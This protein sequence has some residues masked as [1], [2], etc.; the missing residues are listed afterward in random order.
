MNDREIWQTTNLNA[1][2]QRLDKVRS[3]R[4]GCFF[5]QQSGNQY[6]KVTK[7]KS[8][9]TLGFSD[10]FN[11]PANLIQSELDCDRP[12]NLKSLYT[13]AMM[14]SLVWN[15]TPQRIY[16]AGLGGG[17]IPLVLHHYFPE[18][19]IECAEIDPAILQVATNFFGLKLDERLSVAIQDGRE[20]LAQQNAN[21]KYDIILSDVFLGTGYSPYRLATQ[22][23]YELCLQR[24]SGQG[25]VVVNLFQDDAFFADK[26]LTIK[27]VF[28]Q[29][30]VVL[31]SKMGNAIVIA[32][33]GDIRQKRE[34]MAKAKNLANRYQFEFPLAE[35]ALEV[36]M[37]TQLQE[38]VPK[39]EKAR[40]LLDDFP[41][42]D[43][44][45]NLPAVNPAIART[46][47]SRFCMCGSGK[48]Q[49]DCHG[50]TN[51]KIIST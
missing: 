37:G 17:I 23:F 7:T 8:T 34:V 24:L 3:A 9:I 14:L 10:S 18:A 49:N 27:S 28:E 44:F 20:Y 35:R 31:S 38:Y 16:I 12:L 32:N 40:V 46:G 15:S 39:L 6:I 26:L 43:Y 1:I 25:V 42:S 47:G 2:K 45:G 29:V 30:Y 5:V 22:E 41:P 51:L 11:S 33:N 4:P 19:V 13:Q 21:I 36:K 50:Q 48:L